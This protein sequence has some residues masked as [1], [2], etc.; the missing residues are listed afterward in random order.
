MHIMVPKN[1]GNSM[2]SC[3]DDTKNLS[4]KE[5]FGVFLWIQLP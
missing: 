4:G 5:F 1:L 3:D 2:E